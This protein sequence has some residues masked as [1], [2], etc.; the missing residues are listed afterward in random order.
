MKLKTHNMLIACSKLAGK[1]A[2][3]RT[4]Q[5]PFP[6]NVILELGLAVRTQNSKSKKYQ[7]ICEPLNMQVGSFLLKKK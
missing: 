4:G 3:R 1:E 6:L 7:S 5:K 2:K